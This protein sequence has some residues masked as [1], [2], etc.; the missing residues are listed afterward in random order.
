MRRAIA[1]DSWLYNS[2]SKVYDYNTELAL[3]LF[4]QAGWKDTDGDGYFEK[5][6]HRYDE[7]TLKLLVNKSTDSTRET[8][9]GR[10]RKPA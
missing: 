8:A 1:P 2:R 5:N 7:L 4:D 3:S 10:Y 9:A 6:A